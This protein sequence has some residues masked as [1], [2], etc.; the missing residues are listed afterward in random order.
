M[1]R[2]Q[3]TGPD[4]AKYEITAP[5]QASESEVLGY[6]RTQFE[7]KQTAKAAPP[8]VS[9]GEMAADVAK[10]TG[11]GLAQGALGLATLPG[12][13][14]A[15]GRLGINA[16]AGVV[17]VKAPVGNETYLTTYDDAKRRIEPITGEFYKPQTT[18]GKYART[19]GEF[20]T[21]ALGGG[22]GL[23]NRVARVGGPAVASEFAGQMTE[24]TSAEPWARVG[25]AI[26]GGQLPNVARRLMT[27]APA[28]PARA[29]AV[30]VL[31]AEGVNALTAGQRTGS[32]PLRWLEDATATV[33]GG[34][35]RAVAAQTQAAEQ[36][37]AAALRRAGIQADRATPDVMD[38]AFRA[39]GNEYDALGRLVSV[40]NSPAFARRLQTIAADYE[41]LTPEAMRVPAV[42]N[43]VDDL[44]QRAGLAG[45][46][47]NAFYSELRRAQRE[48][49]TDPRASDAVGRIVGAMEAQMVQSVPAGDRARMARY[50]RDLSTRY[51]NML[52]IEKA[53]GSAGENAAMGLI[54]PAAL[55]GAVKGQN[56]RDYTRGRSELANLA[57]AGETVLRPLPSSGTSERGMAQGMLSAPG[58]IAGVAVGGA[59]PISAAIGSLVP[60]A[61]KAGTAQAITSPYGQR[62]LGNQ[63]FV[64]PGPAPAD[65]RSVVPLLPRNALYGD[66]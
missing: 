22:A 4:G 28:E 2:Y 47:Y 42:R 61:A 32:R 65:A 37:T 17:G 45:D 14:E 18:V 9:A 20:A 5:D 51:R 24:G 54:S 15:L 26:V 62:F 6:A 19:A 59:D 30:Q 31:E 3:I 58:G 16:A 52:A 60:W 36:F 48:L 39:I 7:A 35:G 38:T 27:P 43:V 64:G 53:A 41:R 49:K 50:V 46:Q 33:P 44:T 23:A 57:R 29:A 40:Q 12:N 34:G 8:P 10:S 25:G 11:I 66:E 1:A 56:A 63:R 13:L 21:L 55:K